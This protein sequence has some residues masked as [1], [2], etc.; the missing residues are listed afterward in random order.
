MLISLSQA[1][2]LYRIGRYRLY[3][4]SVTHGQCDIRP[5]VTFPAIDRHRPLAGTNLYC[6]LNRDT[7]VCT[8]CP[9]SFVQRSGRD[10]NLRPIGCKSDALINVTT[11][12]PCATLL[13]GDKKYPAGALPPLPL[14]LAR[15]GWH[16]MS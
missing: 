7:C 4:E 5:T 14:P 9:G 12:P 1:L 13:S 16:D 6:L 8:T 2:E 15:Y 10:S 11:T 3:T